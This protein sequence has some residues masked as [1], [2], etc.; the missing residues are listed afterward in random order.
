MRSRRSRYPAPP[1]QMIAWSAVPIGSDG[2]VVFAKLMEPA[3]ARRC[4]LRRGAPATTAWPAPNERMP[5]HHFECRHESMP[6]SSSVI[7][8]FESAHRRM[9]ITIGIQPILKMVLTVSSCY[10]A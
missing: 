7:F 1:G 10:Q 8:Q 4:D 3:R 9:K 2:S 6:P 5:V